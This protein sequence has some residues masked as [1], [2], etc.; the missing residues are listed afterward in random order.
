MSCKK[1]IP[2]NF[3]NFLG[4]QL[5]Q[6]LFFDKVAGFRPATLLKKRLWQR[7][8]P[9][10]FVKFLRTPFLMKHLWWLLTTL[11]TLIYMKN[12]NNFVTN[13][14]DYTDSQDITKNNL[15]P[16]STDYLVFK[17]RWEIISSLTALTMLRKKCPYSELF[18][19]VFSRIWTRI[20]PNT[21]SFLTDYADFRGYMQ[22][23]L[24]ITTL[25]TL[26]YMTTW[27]VI[28]SLTTLTILILQTT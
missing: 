21:D 6:S 4:K 28:S 26:I 5:C 16:E 23:N 15:I 24:I 13:Y 14:A 8:F 25:T 9:K 17:T 1:G 12:A 18:W 3:T 2:R 7:C 22:N 20:T 11:I 10:N 19:S 27:K